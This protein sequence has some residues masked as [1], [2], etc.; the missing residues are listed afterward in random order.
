MMKLSIALSIVLIFSPLIVVGNII[1]I[2]Y[3]TIV[4]EICEN[5]TLKLHFSSSID[6]NENSIVSPTLKCIVI[7]GYV[8]KFTNGIFKNV[9]NLKFLDL[10]NNEINSDDLFTFGNLSNV[11]IL[12]LSNQNGY[13]NYGTIVNGVYPEL[14]YLNLRNAKILDLKSS[15]DNPFPKLKY[16]DLSQ[17]RIESRTFLSIN[18]FSTLT[19]LDLSANSIYQF[20]F[21]QMENLLS[22]TLDRNKIE[23]LESSMGINLAGLEKLEKLSLAYNKISHIN[24]S[25]IETMSNLRY[26]NLSGNSLS[27]FNFDMLKSVKSLDVLVL[28]SNSLDNVLITAPVNLTQLS[29]NRNDIRYLAINT[30]YYLHSLKKLFLSENKIQSIQADAFQNQVLLEELYL[31]DNQL[32]YLPVGWCE[33]MKMLRYLNLAGNKFTL[34]ESVIY[35]SDLPVQHLHFERNPLTYINGSLSELIPVNMTIY[36]NV[37]VTSKSMSYVRNREE[38]LLSRIILRRRK[39]SH[40]NVSPIRDLT[41]TTFAPSASQQSDSMPPNAL[42]QPTAHDPLDRKEEKTSPGDKPSQALISLNPLQ[43][44][45]CPVTVIHNEESNGLNSVNDSEVNLESKSAADSPES[46]M[47]ELSRNRFSSINTS[48]VNNLS[49]I[50]SPATPDINIVSESHSPGHNQPNRSTWPPTDKLARKDAPAHFLHSP[51]IG[52]HLRRKLSIM[53]INSER[54]CPLKPRSK[55]N[56]PGYAE[57]ADAIAHNAAISKGQL[58]NDTEPVK[59]RHNGAGWLH[60]PA[61]VNP[62]PLH[63]IEWKESNQTEGKTSPILSS[64]DSWAKPAQP[65]SIIKEARYGWVSGGSPIPQSIV[66]LLHVSTTHLHTDFTCLCEIGEM[67]NDT[68]WAEVFHDTSWAELFHDTSWF[69][70]FNGKFLGNAEDH[71]DPDYKESSMMKLSIALSIVLI[72]S[73]LIVV[74]NITIDYDTIV[75]E[76][77]ENET[78]KL[79]FSSSIDFNEN[80]IVSPTLKCIV[81]KGYVLTFTN[82]IFKNVPNLK[83]LD[84]S[85]NGINSNNLFTFGNLSNVKILNLSNQNGYSNYGT[86]VNGVYPEL[87]Y[88]NL[89]NAK[90]QELKSS[91]DNPFPKLKYLDLSQNGIDSRSSLLI[92]MF[93]TLTHLDLSANSIYQ[94]SFGQMENLLSLTLDR[95]KIENLE[96]SRGINLAGLEKL[97]KLSLAY[98]KISYINSRAIETMSN[99][100]YLNLSGNSLSI[101]NFDMLKSVKS[102]DVLVLDSNSLDN[103]LITAPV[104]LTQLSLNRNDIRYLAI[105][106]FYYLHSLKKLFLSENKI[107]SIQADAFQNQVLLEELY[108]NDNQLSYLPI[109]WCE[110]MKMLRYLNLAGNKFTLLESVIYSSDLPVQ[111]LHFERNPLTYINGSLSRLIPVNMTIYLNVS[112]TSESTSYLTTGSD[113]QSVVLRYGH[114]LQDHVLNDL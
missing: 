43:D 21:G 57:S 17:N 11:K 82:G 74:G 112:V 92:N 110:S 22:L 5:E 96:S 24:S 54:N 107:Q 84:L 13:S 70:N 20:S 105:N 60:T 67:Y 15:L 34:L 68:S 65:P 113:R 2:D 6:F 50:T 25:A 53:L 73:P 63:P 49:C 58:R 46:T 77:C 106:T 114:L 41:T 100:R 90:I 97:E 101:F 108:L 75:N 52:T 28:D 55:H 23:N 87:E 42:N 86:I 99:L 18:M 109:G 103:V 44:V 31:N 29:L 104:N 91:L 78:L 35:S 39:I 27:I 111:H 62:N 80:S 95:N 69:V 83:F 61:A 30:F 12:N 8:P 10:S 102:L 32:S 89:R 88:L 76:I 79:H 64:A 85:N 19:H 93:S 72:F 7:K 71:G 14:E 66:D 16:L 3:D 4:N 1:V 45:R 36:L 81:I 26:L 51:S 48:T 98:N 9:P 56:N 37:N 40:R 33:S 59:Y 47:I 38:L 94:F